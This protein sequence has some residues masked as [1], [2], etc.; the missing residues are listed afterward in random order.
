MLDRRGEVY[1]RLTVHQFVGLTKHQVS[2]WECLCVCGKTTI[3]SSNNLV[4]GSIV[5]CGCY[6]YEMQNS[7]NVRHG[8]SRVSR[9]HHI[10]PEYRIWRGMKSRCLNP[11]NPKYPSYGGRGITI[12]QRW[13]TFENFLADMGK[14][15]EG[16]SIDRMDNESNYEPG[17][18]RWATA[19]EQANNRRPYPSLIKP[20]ASLG[21]RKFQH[22]S[23]N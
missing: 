11:K 16:L 9:G 4:S 18:C 5:S 12:C 2:R 1:G 13:L 10:T 19:K 23:L 7:V 20:R 15:P 17:N 14:R 22:S 3:V 8:N 21:R 6:R